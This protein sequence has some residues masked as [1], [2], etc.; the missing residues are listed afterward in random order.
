MPSGSFG[1]GSFPV[2]GVSVG[3]SV[4]ASVGEDC[5]VVVTISS[6]G[7]VVLHPI[8]SRGA[9]SKK[10]KRRDIFLMKTTSLIVAV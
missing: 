3:L 4:G 10:A 9:Q 6:D 2:V 1:V 5:A 7:V 8:K